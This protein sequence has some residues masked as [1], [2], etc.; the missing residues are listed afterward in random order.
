MATHEPVVLKKVNVFRVSFWIGAVALATFVGLS[1]YS[2][3]VEKKRPGAAYALGLPSSAGAGGEVAARQFAVRQSRDPKSSVS[4]WER[5][6][7][8]RAFQVEPLSPT[9][10]SLLV[11]ARTSGAENPQRQ[12]LLNL[13]G[14]LSR[15]NAYIGTQQLEAAGLRGDNK[16]F[17]LWMSRL[18]LTN[19]DLRPAY[20]RGMAE[21][22]AREGA[23]EALAPVLGPKPDWAG[24]YW[25]AVV[26]RRPSL[27]NAATLRMA[28]ARAPWH[29]ADVTPHDKTLSIGLARIGEFETARRLSSALTG[30][31]KAPTN[32]NLLQNGS[33]SRPPL[34][35]P[36]DWELATTGSLGASID[37]GT[38]NLA[39]SAIG[40]ARGDAARQLVRLMPGEYQ[41]R[42]KLAYDAPPPK[43]A[44]STRIYCAE[45]GVK[46]VPIDPIELASGARSSNVTVP[47]GTCGWYWVSLYVSLSDDAPG[48][49]AYFESIALV[50]A[51]RPSDA[52]GG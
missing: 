30:G 44:M 37:A 46:T 6:L 49:D 32:G 39:I 11:A 22:T 27:V 2:I 40:G 28:L 8:L 1:S 15:R 5:V 45:E 33:F 31:V 14:Q 35:P 43:G 48:V 21:A 19:N 42:W 9:A 23:A 36:F 34:L 17:F 41:L 51:K 24:D 3:A 12:S 52:Q 13:G 26:Q 10:L 7:A 4:K 18:V 50:P 47:D 20:I 25:E 38:K 16:T 29:Q